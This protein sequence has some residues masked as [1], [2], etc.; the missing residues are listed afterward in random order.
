MRLRFERCHLWYVGDIG[1]AF[2]ILILIDLLG[3][4]YGSAGQFNWTRTLA[5]SLTQGA[6]PS[7]DHSTQT[8]EGYF[9]LA[10]GK[11]RNASQRAFLL[12]P[13]QAR[14]TG[15]C[16]H[17][18]YFHHG[19]P[20][21]MKLSVYLSTA[22]PVLWSHAGS[23]DRRWLY[24]QVSLK[25]PNEPWRAVFESEVLSNNNDGSIAIDDVS[26]TRGLCPKPGDCNF[27]SGICGWTNDDNDVEMIWL[28][29]QGVHSFGTG[30]QYGKR[31]SRA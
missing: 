27:E 31:G 10:E 7:F 3:Y 4:Q 22:G 26:I 15:S 28:I 23:I 1:R 30:P 6:H 11:N 29:G 2:S 20:N 9:M 5:S 14:T 13:V 21:Q 24:A 18:W 16:L 17:F 19:P 8:D 25:N 12:T